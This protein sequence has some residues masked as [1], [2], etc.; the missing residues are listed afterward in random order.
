MIDDNV[1]VGTADASGAEVELE[2]EGTRSVDSVDE[3][4]DHAEKV[5]GST[6]V[7]RGTL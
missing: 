3:R 1:A 2:E 6:I 5:A 7:R 4:A